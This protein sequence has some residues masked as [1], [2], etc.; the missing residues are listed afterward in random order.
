M[1]MDSRSQTSFI[2]TQHSIWQRRK[3]SPENA[4]YRPRRPQNS[5]YYHCIE[6]HFET[7]ERVYEER[8]E[9]AYGFYRPYLRSVIYRYLDCGGLRNGFTR[10]RCGEYGHGYLLAFVLKRSGNPALA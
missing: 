3:G 8:F 6:D 1:E 5:S 4:L 9:R 7:F 10:V 2:P